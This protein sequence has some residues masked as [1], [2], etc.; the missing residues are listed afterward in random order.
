MSEVQTEPRR[1]VAIDVEELAGRAGESLGQSSW[2]G[3]TQ[4]RVDRF[5]DATGDRQWIHV[6]PERAATGPFG[7][8]VAHGFLTVSLAPMLLAEV[9]EVGGAGLVVNYGLNR[10]RF[11]APVPVGSRVR[12]RVELL[13]VDD[14]AGGVQAEL[15]VTVELEGSEKPACVMDM[16]FRYYRAA[17]ADAGREAGA[18]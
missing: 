10:V 1:P 16:L 11:P 2:Q 17:P 7:S 14:V 18:P 4:E 13:G 15:R 3:I 9:L 5:A 8:T 6:D 12:G